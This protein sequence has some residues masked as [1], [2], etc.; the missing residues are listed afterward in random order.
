MVRVL[1]IQ[2]FVSHFSSFPFL[3][4]SYVYKDSLEGNLLPDRGPV[5][6]QGR[7]TEIV[8]VDRPL[9]KETQGERRARIINQEFYPRVLGLK[10]L[11]HRSRID[12]TA[13]HTIIICIHVYILYVEVGSAL[14]F[15]S[16]HFSLL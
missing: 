8:I 6:V 10:N 5:L 4:L 9:S 12:E 13:S 14:L 1:N 2:I 15:H 7:W 3:I 11:S 16:T